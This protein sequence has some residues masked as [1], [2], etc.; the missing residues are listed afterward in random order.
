MEK[1][2]YENKNLHFDIFLNNGRNSINID[3]SLL[4]SKV[5]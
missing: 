3:F 2:Q 1:F 5:I 4:Y